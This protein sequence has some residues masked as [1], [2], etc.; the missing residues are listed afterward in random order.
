MTVENET[1]ATASFALLFVAGCVN[2][3][4]DS[5]E[6]VPCSVALYSSIETHLQVTDEQ[7]HGPDIGSGEWK[8]AVEF[9]LGL[10][11]NADVPDPGTDEWCNFIAL[12]L[13]NSEG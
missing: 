3:G 13:N 8:S 5:T 4:D 9:K 11:R 10:R 12:Q 1:I 7:G 2:V 6:T